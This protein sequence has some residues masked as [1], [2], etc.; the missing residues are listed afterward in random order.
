MS[1]KN[2]SFYSMAENMSLRD[3]RMGPREFE[4]KEMKK[5]KGAVVK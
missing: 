3:S 5:Y 2:K 4:H 1:H